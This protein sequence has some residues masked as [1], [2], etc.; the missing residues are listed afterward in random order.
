MT[1]LHAWHANRIDSMQF[2]R[3]RAFCRY[4]LLLLSFHLTRFAISEACL[5]DF[6]LLRNMSGSRFIS[7]CA[8]QAAIQRFPKFITHIKNNA[9]SHGDP[10]RPQCT[11]PQ[12][13]PIQ[14][15]R[16]AF[17]SPFPNIGLDRILH[18]GCANDPPFNPLPS[19]TF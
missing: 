12:K 14:L 1:C 7:F 17:L 13:M 10:Y 19:L 16:V 11:A 4:F 18:L 5:F 6:L 9:A 3:V 8:A 15:A 2:G